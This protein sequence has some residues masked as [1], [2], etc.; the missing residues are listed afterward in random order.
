MIRQYSLHI[1]TRERYDTNMPTQ[2]DRRRYSWVACVPAKDLL[3][4]ESVVFVGK[5]M[6]EPLV[7]LALS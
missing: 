3:H 5:Q 4:E 1:V 7:P 6:R 2:L